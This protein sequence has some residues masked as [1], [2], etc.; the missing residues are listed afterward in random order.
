M[1]LQTSMNHVLTARQLLACE[2]E[3]HLRYAALELRMA[4]EQLFYKLL[5]SYRE[6]LPDD[7][8]KQWQPKKLIDALIDCNPDVEQN[9]TLTFA[10][11]LPD[12]KP[13]PAMMVGR[14]KAVNRKLLRQYYH[15]LGS[16]LHA[17]MN[18]KRNEPAPTRGFLEAA[19]SRIEEY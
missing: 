10:D 11:E 8:L 2:D 5:P 4:I 18:D 14:Y 7:L 12:G 13:G 3:P 6:E 17:S 19:A 15:K 1:L 16:L 9:F